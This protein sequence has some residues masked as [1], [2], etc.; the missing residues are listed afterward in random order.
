MMKMRL[1]ELRRLIR[2]A[3]GGERLALC[4]SETSDRIK[5]VLYSPAEVLAPGA[6]VGKLTDSAALRSAVRGYAV[7]KRP[8]ESLGPCNDAWYVSAIA[9]VGYGA[10]LYGFGY[11][12]VPSGRVMPDRIYS[13]PRA[14]NAWTKAGKKTD[15][16]GNP[17]LRKLP[18]D[19]IDEPVT[20]DPE[21]DCTLQVPRTRGGPDPI[22]DIAYEGGAAAKDPT[23]YV[24]VHEEVL[25][26]LPDDVPGDRFEAA[27]LTLGSSY[28]GAEFHKY[29]REK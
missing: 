18:L 2:E 17:V 24:R 19:D 8:K 5:I 26:R 1:G 28:F 4:V 14:V 20:P 15:P 22:L 11:S 27:L 21:D 9:G 6:D 3:V 29:M 13:A 16:E 7:F 12:L 10:D 23:P 25:D